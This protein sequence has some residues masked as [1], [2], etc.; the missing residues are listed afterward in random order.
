MQKKPTNEQKRTQK[1]YYIKNKLDFYHFRSE[2]HHMIVKDELKTILYILDNDIIAKYWNEGN[3]LYSLYLLATLDYLSKK[4]DIPVA[5]EYDSYRKYK[6]KS[7]F[8]VRDDI[9]REIEII[10]RKKCIPE[11]ERYNILEGELYD[12]K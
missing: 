6:L 1:I 11:F 5:M 10:E 8:Y 3:T 7:P 4:N 12:A 9:Y 2:L